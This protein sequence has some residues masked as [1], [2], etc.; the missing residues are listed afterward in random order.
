MRT[1]SSN[2]RFDSHRTICT[3]A[4]RT[5]LSNKLHY[6]AKDLTFNNYAAVVEW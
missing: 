6:F 5:Q 1:S 3:F 4:S 2:F